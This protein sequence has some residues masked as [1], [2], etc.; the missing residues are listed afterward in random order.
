MATDENFEAGYTTTIGVEGTVKGKYFKDT[1]GLDNFKLDNYTMVVATE[2]SSELEGILG[3]G[4]AIPG[5]STN[6]TVLDAMVAANLIKSR[7][8]SLYLN[9]HKSQTG[10][11]IFGGIDHAK[12][13]GEMLL[14]KSQM[15]TAFVVALTGLAISPY[16]EESRKFKRQ[17]EEPITEEVSAEDSTTTRISATDLATD[18]ATDGASA[19]EPPS[20]EASATEEASATNTDSTADAPGTDEPSA[21][22]VA[23]SFGLDGPI[24]AL[25]N[26][27]MT[28]TMLPKDLVARLAK[29]VGDVKLDSTP[30]YV[31]ECEANVNAALVFQLGG[32]DGAQI[33]VDMAEL[34]LPIPDDNGEPM[35]F[36]G[37]K[38]TAC[39]FGVVPI[40]DDATAVLGQTFLRSAYVLFDVDLKQVGFAQAKWDVTES[41]IE[42]IENGGTVKSASSVAGASITHSASVAT[43]APGIGFGNAAVNVGQ[44]SYPVTSLEGGVKTTLSGDKPRGGEASATESATSQSSSAAA[45]PAVVEQSSLNIVLL[46]PCGL[47]M[48]VAAM[49]L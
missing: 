35:V 43:G 16:S 42:E 29:Y 7:T 5:K 25:I 33:Y 11:I 46:A 26:S 40:D 48:L 37:T 24:T 8:Y 1:L 47:I 20:D 39:A 31:L 17:S 45:A 41:D 3:L 23:Q 27:G 2:A 34:I 49:L 10:A 9:S 22:D 44:P 28:A 12:F 30:Y 4:F 32:D 13:N 38:I 6:V 19:T 36:K 14:L 21:D 18:V 15:D